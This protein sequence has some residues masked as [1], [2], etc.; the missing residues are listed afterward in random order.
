MTLQIKLS[1]LY[2]IDKEKLSVALFYIGML[3]AFL[4]SLN[5]WFLWPVGSNYPVLA[6]LFLVPSYLLSRTLETPIFSRTDF[7]LPIISFLLFALYERFSI[8]SNI[9]G[10]VMLLFR[11]TIFYCLFR[12]STDRLQKF[13]TF[14]CKVMGV[15][16]LASLIG[17]FLFLFGFPLPGRDAQFG[18]FY[19]Y[20]NYY[21]FLLDDRN[22]F[23]IFSRFNSYFLE[24]SHI[25]TAA[26]FLLFTQRGQWRKWYNIVLLVTVFFT[27]SL[28]AY[29]YLVAIVFL[30]LWISGKRFWGKLIVTLGGL[31]VATLTT[32][33]YNNGENLVHDLIML[34][35]E[36][37]DGELAG[38]NRVTGDFDADYDNFVESSDIFF[39]R[40]FEVTEFGNAGYKV[41]FYENGLVGI[42][43]LFAFYF[44]SMMYTTNKRA[45]ISVLIVSILYFIPSAI[46]LWENIFFPL[47]ATAYLGLSTSSQNTIQ[48]GDEPLQHPA[49]SKT[50]TDN[51][52]R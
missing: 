41:F 3:I 20:T 14:G 48:G 34:R 24:P 25:G 26:A 13:M 2:L 27:F 10:Y 40:H 44:I 35:L 7:V 21:L 45:F 46:M 50:N 52:E 22:L 11:L 4:G 28:G 39:G 18:E 49:Y 32:F 51:D 8:E 33:T 15:L 29:I 30:N 31:G 43:L 9:N 42:I 6:C 36:T 47:Y 1:D 37:D 16:L 17:Y 12:I 5:P 38:D 23:A 19:S